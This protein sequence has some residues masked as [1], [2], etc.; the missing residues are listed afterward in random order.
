M[1]TR[2]PLLAAL[3]SLVSATTTTTSSA[4][5]A[6]SCDCYETSTNEYFINHQFHDFRSISNVAAT[7]PLPS[8]LPASN[9]LIPAQ[10][11]YVNNSDF[12]LQQNGWIQTDAWNDD[13]A[14][15]NWGTLPSSD[16]PIRMQNSL[17]NVYVCELS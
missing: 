4:T 17:A 8:G 15:M 11:D 13:W 1:L 9:N 5:A 2:L 7:P 14:T 16:F 12:G 3:A 6:P 10:S